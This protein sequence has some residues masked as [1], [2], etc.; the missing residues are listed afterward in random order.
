MTLGLA[1][2]V[3][4]VRNYDPSVFLPFQLAG[5]WEKIWGK[6]RGEGGSLSVTCFYFMLVC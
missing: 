2:G 4:L 3:T 6:E 5:V 1:L